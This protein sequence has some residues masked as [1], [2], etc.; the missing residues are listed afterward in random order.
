MSGDSKEELIATRNLKEKSTCTPKT[1]EFIKTT[2]NIHFLKKIV[3]RTK[4]SFGFDIF[5]WLFAGSKMVGWQFCSDVTY[6]LTLMGKSFPPLGPVLFT[7]RLQKLDKGLNQYL[8]EAACTFVP[9]V[10]K[11]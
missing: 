10:G 1:C 8:L 7:L 4:R 5:V 2:S 3:E 6:P 9:Q 11:T